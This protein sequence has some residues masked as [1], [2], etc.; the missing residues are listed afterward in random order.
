KLLP[1]KVSNAAKTET[2]RNGRCNK[3]HQAEVGNFVFAG[4]KPHGDDDTHQSSVEC[5][6]AFPDF[7]QPQGIGKKDIQ[8]VEEHVANATTKN[9]ADSS[10]YNKVFNLTFIHYRVPKPAE[11]QRHPPGSGKSTEV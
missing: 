8:L 4:I 9:D 5:H 3:I 6:A 10:V 2:Q 1:D 11:A 7:E